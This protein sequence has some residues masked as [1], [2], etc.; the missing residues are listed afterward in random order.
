MGIPS[1]VIPIADNQKDI[2]YSLQKQ[3]AA[4]LVDY[5]MIEQELNNNIS[6]LKAGLES[7]SRKSYEICDGMGC[8]RVIEEIV[9]SKQGY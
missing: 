2:G 9:N 8:Q 5:E 7:F 1:I 3:S 4:L 6:K